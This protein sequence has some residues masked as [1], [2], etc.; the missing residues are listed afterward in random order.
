MFMSNQS[1]RGLVTPTASWLES[2]IAA[3][4]TSCS[5]ALEKP[6][7]S[8]SPGTR[9]TLLWGRLPERSTTSTPTSTGTRIRPDNAGAG[10]AAH[11]GGGQAPWRRPPPFATVVRMSIAC[12]PGRWQGIFG[13]AL[14]L[15]AAFPFAPGANYFARRHPTAAVRWWRPRPPFGSYPANRYWVRST[16]RPSRPF[17]MS[18]TVR[19]GWTVAG[20][21]QRPGAPCRVSIG[22]SSGARAAP[23]PERWTLRGRYPCET[24]A[25][26]R[27]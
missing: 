12:R 17:P 10:G 2:T 13:G 3:T 26:R 27:A 21:G 22:S 1:T 4:P 9:T 23:V 18:A 25:K 8:P 20:L 16:C 5:Q 24:N 6:T 15:L 14:H 7:T 19:I 11:Q